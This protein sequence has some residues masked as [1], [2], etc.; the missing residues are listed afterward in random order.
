[1]NVNIRIAL[2]VAALLWTVTA[3]AQTQQEASQL[4]REG[5]ALSASQVNDLEDRLKNNPEDFAAR[6]R[7][8]GYYFSPSIAVLGADAT[9]DARR[10][11]ILWI[12]EHHP[13][14]EVTALS[15]ITIDPAGHPLADAEGYNKAK[16]LWLAQIGRHNDEVPVLMH[17]ARFS[18]LPDRALALDLLKEAVRLSPRDMNAAHELGYTYAVTILGITMINGNGLPMAVDPG[19]AASALGYA[20]DQRGAR[21]F[22]LRGNY[23]RCRHTRPVWRDSGRVQ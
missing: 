4:A 6:T 19:A 1:M 22:E 15:E 12:I 7:L 8:L 23:V 11:H 20:I 21:V 2:V 16:S 18:R 5:W 10:R 13:E 3:G 14:S 9:R 17:A